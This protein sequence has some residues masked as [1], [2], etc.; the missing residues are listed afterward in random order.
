MQSATMSMQPYKNDFISDSP[1]LANG[2][3]SPL[4]VLFLIARATIRQAPIL[5]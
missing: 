4:G 2:R 1:S 5:H 3:A